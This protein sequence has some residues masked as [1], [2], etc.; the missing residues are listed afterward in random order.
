MT[1]ISLLIALAVER[2][3]VKSPYWHYDFYFSRYLELIE[4]RG[5]GKDDASMVSVVALSLIPAIIVAFMS[6]MVFGLF[7]SALFNLA[8]LLICLGCPMQRASYKG[9]LRA[10]QQGDMVACDLY[11]GQMGHDE[12]QTEFSFGQNLVWTNYSHYAAVIVAFVFFGGAGAVFY[13][14]A[15]NIAGIYL[16]RESD[17][18]KHAEQVLYFIDWFPVRITA[19]G[20]LLVGHFSR[21]MPVWLAELFNKEVSAKSLLAKVS[22]AAEEIDPNPDDCTEEPCTMVRLAKRNVIFMLMM[23]SLLTLAGV[24]G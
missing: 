1:L 8:L 22:K 23:L 7:L 12:S 9:F 3:T 2:V 11:S 15:R 24:V 19:L 17:A 10:A 16:N 13:V 20:F 18:A 4:K 6:N 14:L 5:W 21:A